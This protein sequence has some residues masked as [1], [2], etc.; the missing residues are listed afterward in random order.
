MNWGA[1]IGRLEAKWSPLERSIRW[2]TQYLATV[3]HGCGVKR[4][5]PRAVRRELPRGLRC[6]PSRLT[7][8][9]GQVRTDL[10]AADAGDTIAMVGLGAVLALQDPPDLA[11]ARHWW[12]QAADAGHTDAMLGLGVLALAQC[13]WR[14]QQ[15][16]VPSCFKTCMGYK[17]SKKRVRQSSSPERQLLEWALPLRPLKMP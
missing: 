12:Q 13:W 7:T 3:S 17:S 14:Q 10:Q 5:L 4:H 8:A 11:A 16:K 2:F 6:G 9:G 15:G 1:I